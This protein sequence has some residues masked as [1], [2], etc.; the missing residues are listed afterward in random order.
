MG[1][2]KFRIVVTFGR[3]EGGR[4][5]REKERKGERKGPQKHA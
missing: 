2:D 1:M 5:E 4:N 3:E